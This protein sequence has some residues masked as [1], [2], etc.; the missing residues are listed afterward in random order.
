M[1]IMTTTWEN[2]NDGHRYVIIKTYLKKSCL[3]SLPKIYIYIKKFIK[4]NYNK[5][6]YN[7]YLFAKSLI[8]LLI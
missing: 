6:M 1:V 2:T 4:T 3:A 7:F 8:I 5:F